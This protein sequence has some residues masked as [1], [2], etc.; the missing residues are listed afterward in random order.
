MKPIR[1]K[2]QPIGGSA[3][4]AIPITLVKMYEWAPG[5][6]VKAKLIEGG[7]YFEKEVRALYGGRSAGVIIPRP[8]LEAHGLETG[9]E[10]D[11]P[12]YEW[13]TVKAVAYQEDGESAAPKKRAAPRKAA[14]VK[15]RK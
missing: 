12:F 7:G 11:I 5:A 13:V 2:V 8:V 14:V 15:A 1:S 6:V 3:C 9:D 10:I 4:I